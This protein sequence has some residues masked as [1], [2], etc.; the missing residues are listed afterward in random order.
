[1]RPPLPPFTQETAKAKVQ[2]AENAW[3]SRNP[4]KVALAYTVDSQWR[5]RSEFIQG[6]AQIREFLTR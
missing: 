1:M 5:N 3:T 2:A 4:E 6:R